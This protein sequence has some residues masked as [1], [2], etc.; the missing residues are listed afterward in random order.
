MRL[1][2]RS[3]LI[4]GGALATATLAGGFT[5]VLVPRP[6][7]LAQDTAV[8]VTAVPIDR[9]SVSDPD[10]TRFGSLLFRSGLVLKSPVSGFGGFSALWRSADGERLVAVSDNAHW[11]RARVETSEGR[12]SGLGD[13]VLAPLLL[14]TGK[15]LAKSR[16]FDT[17]SLAIAGRTAFIGVERSQDVIRFDWDPAGLLV[18]GRPIPVPEEVKDLPNN[19]GLEAMA[20]A[21]RGS[22]LAG[23]LVAVAERDERGS[24]TPTKGFILTGRHRGTFYVARSDDYEIADLA[25]LPDGHLL[26]LDRRFSLLGGFSIR[27]RCID[28]RAVRPGALVDGPVLYESDATQQIDIMEG[29][30]VHREGPDTVLTLISDDNFSPFQRTILLEFSLAG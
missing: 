4:G 14:E 9:L 15:P 19:R 29:L 11:L 3:F 21:P 22:A 10:R 18:R 27:L 8:S 28:G 12:L 30:S 1:S 17:E 16:F 25:F 26:L 2:R 6:R 23:S 24:A 5:D 20:V 7:P 13:T